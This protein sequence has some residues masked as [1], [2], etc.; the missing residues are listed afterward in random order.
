MIIFM[1]KKEYKLALKWARLDELER[2]WRGGSN[3]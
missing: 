1:P 2:L 3:E